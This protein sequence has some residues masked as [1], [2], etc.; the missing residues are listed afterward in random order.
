MLV[1]LSNIVR[2]NNKFAHEI[3]ELRDQIRQQGE[4]SN[5]MEKSLSRLTNENNA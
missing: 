2:E 5:K 4:K 1:D 3:A